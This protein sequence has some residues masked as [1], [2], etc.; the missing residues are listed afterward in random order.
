M[1]GWGSWFGG[2]GSA[3]KKK[4]TIKNSILQLRQTH[5]MLMKREKHLQ[6]QIDDSDAKARKQLAAG[7]K[8]GMCATSDL[9]RFPCCI[10]RQTLNMRIEHAAQRR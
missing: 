2:G 3:Q 5:E 6:N 7:N 4:D 8:A 9:S 10:S 1:S